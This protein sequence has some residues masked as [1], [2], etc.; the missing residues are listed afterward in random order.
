MDGCEACRRFL[1]DMAVMADAIRDTASRPQ[2]PSAVRERLFK[3]VARARTS[4]TAPSARPRGWLWAAAA[5]VAI[6]FGVVV[7]GRA[8]QS[9]GAEGAMA[10]IAEDHLRAVKGEGVVSSDSL[11]VVQWLAERVPT[12]VDVPL[13]PA[14]RLKGGRLSI[15]DGGRGAVLEYDLNGR[16]LSYYIL[17]ASDAGGSGGPQ[18]ARNLPAL[19]HASRGGYR[20]VAWQDAGLVHAL[21]ADLPQARLTELAHYCIKQVMSIALLPRRLFDRTG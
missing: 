3:A 20:V 14:A 6:T 12:P 15:V 10:T 21:V 5:V 8:L 11:T 17:P 13:F 1:S 19:R 7:G 9:R 16:L 2:A 18:R 4:S